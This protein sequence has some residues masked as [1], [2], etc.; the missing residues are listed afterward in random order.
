MEQL[1]EETLKDLQKYL[2]E[3]GRLK[4]FPSKHRNKFTCLLYLSTKFKTGI[5]YTEKEVNELIEQ[6]HTFGDKWLLRRELVD[7]QFLARKVDGSQY[8][9]CEETP[10]FHGN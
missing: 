10:T 1:S 9:L 7:R 8:W 4:L 2:D 6:N 5:L 3:E